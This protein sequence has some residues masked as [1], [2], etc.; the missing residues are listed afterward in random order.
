MYLVDSIIKQQ[1]D[2]AIVF[3]VFECTS[4][5]YEL[6]II[7]GDLEMSTNLNPVSETSSIVLTSTGSEANVGV[8]CPFGIYTGSV[9]FL[10]GASA[11]VSYTYKKLGGDVVDIEL[12]PSNVYA[13]YEESVLEYSYIINLH[14]SKNALSS[15]LGAPTGTFNHQGEKISGPDNVNLS[16]PRFTIGY[17]RR[18]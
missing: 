7:A 8:A 14:Q 10:S 1:A 13:A 6:L 3:K 16:Y 5:V 11:Q 17:S 2:K 9:E 18:V 12:T 4:S 15:F